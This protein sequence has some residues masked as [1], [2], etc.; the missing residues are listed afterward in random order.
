[1]NVYIVDGLNGIEDIIDTFESLILNVQFYGID[2]FEF[3]VPGTNK[4]ITRLPIGKLLVREED[5]TED[6]YKNVM[7][8]QNRRIDYDSERGWLLT[9]TGGGLKSIVRQRCISSQVGFSGL[10]EQGLRQIITDNI[11]DPE[12][13]ARQIPNFVL[14]A[15]QGYTDVFE[16][17]LL[18][19]NIADW[20]TEILPSYGIGWT[21][22]IKNGQYVLTFKKGVNR[23]YSQTE[24]IPVVFSPEF[25][26][27]L[28]AS[29]SY[30]TTEY[31]NAGVVGGEGDGANQ[32]S[33][34]VGSA[35]GLD[36]YE[37][38]IDGSS[39]SS[40]GEIITMETY[41]NMLKEAGNAELNAASHVE[42]FEG[43]IIWDGVYKLN[44]DFFLGDIVQIDNGLM[45]ATTRITEIIYSEDTN[46]SAVTPTFGDFII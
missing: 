22:D 20:M 14:A 25:D 19:E 42:T 31:K 36:R 7:R 21:V 5:A 30:E 38:Y 33:T 6:G 11:I 17:Q 26:N 12:D 2:D 35:E 44:Q 13:S 9:L 40:N 8:I 34:T 37:T 3:I 1:M 27:L 28:N 15:E 29:Y 16:C 4:N 18:G 23:S 45:Q 43:N 32:V 10:V 24:N 46:G 39:V 41:I